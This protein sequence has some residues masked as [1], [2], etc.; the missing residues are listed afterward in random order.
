[1]AGIAASHELGHQLLHLLHPFGQKHCLMNP[2]PMFAYRAWAKQLSAKD[3]AL[4]SSKEM[5][6][7]AHRFHY[8]QP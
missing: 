7:G 4:G 3:C 6:P 5:T 1:M 8:E 2:V